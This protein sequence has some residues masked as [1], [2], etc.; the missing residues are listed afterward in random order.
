MP[1]PVAELQS[2][3]IYAMI[4]AG[5]SAAFADKATKAFLSH[6]RADEL[7]FEMVVRT[8]QLDTL[9]RDLRRARTGNYTKLKGALTW[10]AV[11]GHEMDLSKATPE[12]LEFIPGVGPKTSRFFILWTRPDARYAALDVHILRWLRAEGYLAPWTTPGDQ[13]KYRHWE[14]VFLA[15]ADKRGLTPAVLDA[16]IWE[17]GAKQVM[18]SNIEQ[19]KEA[20]SVSAGG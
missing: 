14:Q 8:I 3:L 19:R 17:A 7:P 18:P 4:V 5:K 2:R 1:F 9:D 6:R 16:Q 15:E 10:I 20:P 12:E 13:E 11:H